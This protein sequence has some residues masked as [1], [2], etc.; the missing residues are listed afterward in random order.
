MNKVRGQVFQF[1]AQ[2]KKRARIRLE[3]LADERHRNTRCSKLGAA[4]SVSGQQENVHIKLGSRQ[5][6]CQQT[7]LFFG[8]PAIHRWNDLRDTDRHDAFSIDFDRHPD[9][10]HVAVRSIS[11]T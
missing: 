4:R 7:K 3:A 2:S 11:W 1:T 9:D 5:I 6:G 8:T 10:A